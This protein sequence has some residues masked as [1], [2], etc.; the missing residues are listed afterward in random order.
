MKKYKVV[1]VNS[2]VNIEEIYGKYSDLAA[3]QPPI[4]LCCLAAY[5][6]KFKYDVNIVDGSVLNLDIP[7]IANLVIKEAPDLIG[8]YSNTANFHIVSRLASEIKSKVNGYKLVVGG[9][10]PTFMPQETLEQSCFDF[11][12][13]GEG[14][15]TLLELARYLQSS[16]TDFKQIDGLAFKDKSGNITINKPRQMIKNLDELPF[17]AVDLLPDLSKYRLYLLH[18]KKLPYM[19]MFTTRGCPHLCVFCNTPF[20]KKVRY[21]S[22][23]YVVDYIEYLIR[24]FGIKELHF[25]DDTFTMDEG[26]VSDICGLLRS[27]RLKVGWY[28]AIRANLNNKELLKEMKRSGC[29]IVAVGAESGHEKIL[30]IIKKNVTLSQI[31]ATCKAVLKAGIKLKA[32]FIIGHPGETLESID[33]TISFAKGLNAHFP[34]FSLMTPYPGAELWD[35]AEKYG[36]FDR[37]NLNKLIISTSDPIFIPYG[38]SKEIL[39]TKQKEAF[40]KI[41]FNIPMVLRQFASIDS[42]QDLYRKI[43]AAIIFLKNFYN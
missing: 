28:S 4:G 27:R 17:P 20:G 11:A 14:E 9:P 19:T 36:S 1:L 18:Y 25:S 10:H 40:R 7:A 38:L 31:S 12:V 39:L 3:F 13:I 8:I 37:S 6:R 41:Y 29:W 42:P 5:L 35:T 30:K 32:F 34:V 43:K 21:H 33:A 22:P 16:D 24:G 26:R 15:D 2:P 23:A